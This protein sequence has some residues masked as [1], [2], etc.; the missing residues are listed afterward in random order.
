MMKKILFCGPIPRPGQAPNGG[1]EA[2]NRRSIDALRGQGRTVDELY[3]PQPTGKPW[4]KLPA[5]V[6]GF[7]SLLRE[8]PQ[9]QG[10][11]LHLTGLY[12]QFVLP[13]ILLLRRARI[14]GL[15]TVYDI[16]AGSMLRYYAR[17]GA[18]YRWLFRHLLRRADIVMIEGMEYADFVRQIT[19]KPAFYLPNHISAGKLPARTLGAPGSGPVRL[20][21][22]GRITLEKGIRTVL[23]ATRLLAQRGVDCSLTVAG[24]GPAALL[25]QLR[26]EYGDCAVRWPGALSS[27]QVLA[28]FG[29]AHFFLFPTRHKGEGHSNAL[30]E[31][32]G[33]GCMPLASENGFNRSVIGDIGQILPLDASAAD[34]AD[35]VQTWCAGGR[36]QAASTAAMARTQDLFSTE[37]A[38]SR[39]LAAY[40]QP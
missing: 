2:C 25:A 7:A 13:E 12:K 3:Y 6:L 27:E 21:Y 40:D 20:V 17:Y 35:A 22:A 11:L 36:W 10:Q 29:N 19:G 24:P 33:M 18:L 23:E 37:Q 32:M 4:K 38:I 31:A 5:Y 30:T 14:M 15:R 26:E 28:E 8:L 1:Y 9:H 39:L 34:Y 16:R